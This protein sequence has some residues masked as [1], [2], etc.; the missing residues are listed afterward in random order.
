MKI[1][2]KYQSSRPNEHEKDKTRNFNRGL[3]FRLP[4]KFSY[5]WLT[6]TYVKMSKSQDRTC[7]ET[8]GI[9]CAKLVD[10]HKMMVHAKFQS[11]KP[12]GFKQIFAS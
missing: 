11:S 9:L 1:N 10:V 8:R 4:R 7:N 6:Y 2:T 12:F 5:N 3:G